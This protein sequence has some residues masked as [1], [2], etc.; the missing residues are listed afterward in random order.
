MIDAEFKSKWALWPFMKQIFGYSLRY[1]KW[2]YAFIGTGI[3]VAIVEA[4]IPLVW[5]HYID[6]VITPI[7]MKY[8]QAVATGSAFEPE[9]SRIYTYGLIYLGLAVFQ[10]VYN[11]GIIHFAGRIEEYV[12]FDLRRDMFNKLQWLSFSYY[13]NAAIGWLISRITSDTDRVTELISWGFISLVWGVIMILVC[14]V[15]MFIYSWQ[16]ALVV[17]LAIPLLLLLGIKLRLLILTY[18]RRARK[19]NSEMTATFNEHIHGI[20]VNKVTTQE[21]T[22]SE[23]FGGLSQNMRRAAFR[24]SYYSAM[25]GPLTVTVGSFAAAL[26]IYLGGNM[27]LAGSA[28]ITVGVLAAFFGYARMIFEPILDISRFYALAQSSLSAGERI[29]SLIAEKRDIYDREGATDFGPI[30]GDIEFE[31]VHFHYVPDKPILKGLN[32]A[33]KA[34]ESIALVGPTGEGKTTITNLICRFYEPTGGVLKIDG[35]DYKTKT[36]KSFRQQLG[37]ILQTPH[38]FSGTIIENI[39]YAD[40]DASEEKIVEILAAIGA[41]D[42]AEQLH[43]HVGEEG[44]TLSTGEKQMIAIARVMLRDP[45]ILMMDEATSSVD[46][47]AEAKMQQGIEKVIQGRTSIIIAHRLSTI[48]NCDRI[49]VIQKG[50]IAEQGSHRQLIRKKG[51]YYHL[52]TMQSRVQG[53]AAVDSGRKPA[54]VE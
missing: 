20:E 3:G 45:K 40:Q 24:A 31:N 6:N 21:D 39:R 23:A 18:A 29:F 26:V 5:L 42:M 36:L 49:F 51:I 43:K 10:T 47:I 52:Y 33:I 15:A 8:K 12:V 2:F 16:L 38:V 30:R 46:A 48:R 14:M 44:S 7:V 19:I 32:L 54:A 50:E 4:I 53:S 9:I 25:Y 1:P 22:A 37:V 28:G 11:G 17:L 34:G 13:D 35:Q 41:D 27:A